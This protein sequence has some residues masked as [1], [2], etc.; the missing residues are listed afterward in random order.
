MA[1]IPDDEFLVSEFEVAQQYI[2]DHPEFALC[3]VRHD[4]SLHKPPADMQP[5]DGGGWV[6]VYVCGGCQSQHYR[7]YWPDGRFHKSWWKYEEGYN[8]ERGSGYALQTRSGK[9]AFNIAHREIM[10]GMAGK[11][12]RRKKT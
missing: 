12:S 6:F 7:E 9:A 1:E 10:M 8:A 4:I 3:R 2:N 11:P 5:A